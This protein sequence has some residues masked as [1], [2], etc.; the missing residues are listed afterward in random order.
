MPTR[1]INM[2]ERAEMVG[3]K[4]RVNGNKGT[5]HTKYTPSG[6]PYPAI[7]QLGRKTGS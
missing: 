7:N 1:A 4:G 2:E 5:A 6:N 3:V